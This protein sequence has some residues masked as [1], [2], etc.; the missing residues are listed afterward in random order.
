MCLRN[1]FCQTARKARLYKAPHQSSLSFASPNL[2]VHVNGEPLQAVMRLSQSSTIAFLRQPWTSWQ[3]TFLYCTLCALLLSIVI[4][5]SKKYLAIIRRQ[6]ARPAQSSLGSA[7]TGGIL[8]S[9]RVYPRSPYPQIPFIQIS[10]THSTFSD[11]IEDSTEES[12]EGLLRT[13]MATK[14]LRKTWVRVGPVGEGHIAKRRRVS[15]PKT[16]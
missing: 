7:P 15:N 6:P 4:F 8:T 3:S 9:Q 5:L 16:K 11:V 13:N 10:P 14:P 12:D 1:Q 2:Y